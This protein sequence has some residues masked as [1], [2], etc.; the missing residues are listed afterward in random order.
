M[1]VFTLIIW[2]PNEHSIYR[3]LNP[4]RVYFYICLVTR[5]NMYSITKELQ[6]AVTTFSLPQL[7]L[8]RVRFAI[9]YVYI[10]EKA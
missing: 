3:Y 1:L 6:P 4:Y 9:Q 2:T 5:K 7:I 8:K 10:G